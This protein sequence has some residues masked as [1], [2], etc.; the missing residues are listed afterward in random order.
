MFF[1][2]KAV[3]D[4]AYVIRAISREYVMERLKVK[5]LYN[6]LV[7][8]SDRALSFLKFVRAEVVD[9]RK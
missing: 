1:S 3:M 4:P 9:E 2:P 6:Q 7:F 8:K 5:E